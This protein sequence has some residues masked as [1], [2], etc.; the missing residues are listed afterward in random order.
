MK[1]KMTNTEEANKYYDIINKSIDLY[2][3]DHKV[4]G[5]R[6]L[7]YF[8]KG[9]AKYESLIKRSGLGNIENIER[10]VDD[11]LE[12][13]ALMELDIR[14]N[15]KSKSRRKLKTFEG[16]MMKESDQQPNIEFEKA[17]ADVYNCGLSHI[18]SLGKNE[19]QVS[20]FGELVK[21]KI[22]TKEDIEELRVKLEN[23]AWESS[24]SINVT[25]KVKSVGIDKISLDQIITKD[26]F[27]NKLENKI[28]FKSV[29]K[30]ISK[31][32]GYRF[33]TKYKE[34]YVWHLLN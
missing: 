32:T 1:V 24:K 12:D 26:D 10:I 33:K 15:E 17:L 7:S 23:E 30:T 14:D 22:Y 28:S 18:E 11:V 3:H 29:L 4:L 19:Y 8:K 9:S 31:S 6:L 5:T 13:R 16:F 34:Y 2:T 27:I 20:D 25:S 21:C